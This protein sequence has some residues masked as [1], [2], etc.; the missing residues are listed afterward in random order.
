MHC[1]I[2]KKS[3]N[4]NDNERGKTKLPTGIYFSCVN[5]ILLQGKNF[6]PMKVL[7]DDT[8]DQPFTNFPAL[9]PTKLTA[10]RNT[11]CVCSWISTEMWSLRG[12]QNRVSPTCKSVDVH[13][14]KKRCEICF[15]IRRTDRVFKLLNVSLNKITR[16]YVFMKRILA[17][18]TRIKSCYIIF[19]AQKFNSRAIRIAC[20]IKSDL[21]VRIVWGCLSR[22]FIE[23]DSFI[24]PFFRLRFCCKRSEGCRSNYKIRFA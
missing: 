19:G 24:I 20:S 7:P 10:R 13:I 16:V 17:S 18:K 23:L 11:T 2:A 5:H 22:N 21:W 8:Y 14:E 6:F 4:I 12:L 9:P 1:S 15:T 3:V